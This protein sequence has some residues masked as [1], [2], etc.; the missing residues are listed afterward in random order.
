MLLESH[1]AQESLNDAVG[2]HIQSLL[3]FVE[4]DTSQI[5]M[6]FSLL[7]FFLLPSPPSLPPPSPSFSLPFFL[8]LFFFFLPSPPL[9]VHGTCI[10]ILQKT[11]REIF[12]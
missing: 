7:L 12:L 2:S 6:L 8:L 11:L 9:P 3:K 1:E 10:Y 5:V 4:L